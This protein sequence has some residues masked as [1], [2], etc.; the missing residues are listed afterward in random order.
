[1]RHIRWLSANLECPSAASN[2][3]DPKVPKIECSWI[4]NEI[5]GLLNCLGN[6]I[7]TYLKFIRLSVVPYQRAEKLYL[8]QKIKFVQCRSTRLVCQAV[9]HTSSWKPN[10]KVQLECVQRAWTNGY[11]TSVALDYPKIN[12]PSI[13]FI[14]EIRPYLRWI[15]KGD[16]KFKLI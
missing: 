2:F 3:V 1:M 10:W 4:P 11:W 14:T 8:S 9:R 15:L 16:F 5:S 12:T 6:S 13:V 7:Q